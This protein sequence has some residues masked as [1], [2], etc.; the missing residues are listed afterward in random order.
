[1][2]KLLKTLLFSI[3]TFGILSCSEPEN[4]ANPVAINYKVAQV[5]AV[6]YSV[7]L[8][9]TF[10]TIVVSGPSFRLTLYGTNFSDKELTISNFVVTATGDNAN[11][12]EQTV[13]WTPD[14][15]GDNPVVAVVAPGASFGPIVAFVDGLPDG[16]N[17]NYLVDVEF[18]GWFAGEDDETTEDIQE[19]LFPGED[20]N[21]F[22]RFRVRD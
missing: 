15:V 11:G 3:L 6:D 14:I 17:P 4:D 12:L 8:P 16:E 21:K 19:D 20:F 9:G 13:E 1:M 5:I 2:T 22:L 18:F 7:A 10:D